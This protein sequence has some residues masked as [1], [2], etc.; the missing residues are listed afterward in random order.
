M[1]MNKP[2]LDQLR[3]AIKAGDKIPIRIAEELGVSRSGLSRWLSG[4]RAIRIQLL[5]KLADCLG[6][7]IVLEPKT[8]RKGR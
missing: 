1:S 2:V 7:R 4:E 3:D 6:Y 8:K 5:E